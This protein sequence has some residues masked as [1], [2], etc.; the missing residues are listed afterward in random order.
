MGNNY[1]RCKTVRFDPVTFARIEI[2]A[3][4]YGVTTSAY[5]RS[6]VTNTVARIKL[7]QVLDSGVGLCA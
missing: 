3:D 1:T 5:I 7:D 6:L 4:M 2:A